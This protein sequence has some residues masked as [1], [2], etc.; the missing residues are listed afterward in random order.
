MKPVLLP[1]ALLA[2]VFAQAQP[3]IQ[4]QRSLGGSSYDEAYAM[5]PCT[6]GGYVLAGRTRSSN[7]DVN[8]IQGQDDFWVVRLDTAGNILWQ[9]PLGGSAN[10]GAV[11]IRQ[12]ADAGFVVVGWTYSNSGQVS[13]NHGNADAW[14]VKLDNG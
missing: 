1:F 4:W 13:G 9:R 2:A 7:G 3:S 14:V 5:G 10:D 12:T 6:D 11:E 8:G